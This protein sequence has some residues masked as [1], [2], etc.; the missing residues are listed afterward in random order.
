MFS[1]DFRQ[2]AQRSNSV[3][4]RPVGHELLHA[5]SRTEGMDR[6]TDRQR[7]RQTDTTKL[8]FAFR[9]FTKTPKSD[10]KKSSGT[11]K[12]RVHTETPTSAEL[13]NNRRHG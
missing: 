9:N 7:D 11:K 8:I 5:D 13:H 3:K 10:T 4:I 12:T 1:T 6:Q 2:N